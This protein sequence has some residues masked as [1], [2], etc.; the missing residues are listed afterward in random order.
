MYLKHWKTIK[1]SQTTESNYLPASLALPI[2]L[3]IF[4]GYNTVLIFCF[5]YTHAYSAEN[6]NKYMSKI[7]KGAVKSF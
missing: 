4:F 7:E 5:I 3:S 6:S 1:T 2:H